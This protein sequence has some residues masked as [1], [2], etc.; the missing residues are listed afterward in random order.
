MKPLNLV[1]SA[2]GPYAGR[3]EVPLKKL[4]G[5]GLFLICGDTGA[6]KTTIFDAI[7]FALYGEAS[8]S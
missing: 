6:G 8:G 5:S 3:T 7:T 2:F 4:G 1:M